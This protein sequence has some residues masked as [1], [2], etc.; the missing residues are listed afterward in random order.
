MQ[1]GGKSHN[2]PEQENEILDISSGILHLAGSS[3]VPDSINKDCLESAKVLPQVDRKFI[4]VMAGGILAIIDQ[5]CFFPPFC[6]LDVISCSSNAF[7]GSLSCFCRNQE[8]CCFLIPS[9]D[10]GFAV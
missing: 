9:T 2:L 3:L 6:L 8:S 7:S 10:C 1:D 5:V 4:P